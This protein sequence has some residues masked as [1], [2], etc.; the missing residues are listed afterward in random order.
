M[1]GIK[2]KDEEGGL[3]NLEVMIS[4]A[5]MLLSSGLILFGRVVMNAWRKTLISIRVSIQ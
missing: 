1:L 4:F 5:A 3:G 2:R